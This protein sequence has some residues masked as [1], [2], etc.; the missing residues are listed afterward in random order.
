MDAR[1]AFARAVRFTETAEE[2]FNR[3]GTIVHVDKQESE[4]ELA[5][6]YAALG[7]AY[8]AVAQAAVALGGD[9]SLE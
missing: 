1:Y 8:A 3:A 7:T 4:R 5:R 6:T 9:A 2:V